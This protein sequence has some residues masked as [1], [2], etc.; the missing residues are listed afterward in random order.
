MMHEWVTPVTVVDGNR[1]CGVSYVAYTRRRES[2]HT[3]NVH[4]QERGIHTNT[5]F[6]C[7]SVEY[8]HTHTTFLCRSVEYTH[9]HTRFC[10]AGAW[11]THT[12][13]HEFTEGERRIHTHTHK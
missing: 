2:L 1:K 6:L 12:H 7:R 10:C 5:T 13:T 3:H 9:T 8:T 4:V 11:N